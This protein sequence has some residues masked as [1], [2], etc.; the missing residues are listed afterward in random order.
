[1]TDETARFDEELAE[2]ERS[3]QS[4]D[5]NTAREHFTMFDA[6]LTRYMR[7]E[8]RLLFPVLERFTSLAP[9]TTARMRSEHR[10][11]R[12]LV[13]NMWDRIAREDKPGGL[14]VLSSLRSVLL[15]HVAKEEWVL[16]P[17]LRHASS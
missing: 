4:D 6:A 8:E 3:L 2:V 13:D 1:M 17:L 12:Q 16:D 14:E 11:L 10:S 9:A 7:G 5:S 15:L